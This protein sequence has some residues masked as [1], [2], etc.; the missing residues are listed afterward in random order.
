LMKICK[1]NVFFK[2]IGLYQW[3]FMTQ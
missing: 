1:F 2:S 3:S